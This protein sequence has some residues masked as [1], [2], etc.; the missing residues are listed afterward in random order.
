MLDGEQHRSATGGNG[1]GDLSNLR[2]VDAV[3][4]VLGGGHST[5]DG[6]YLRPFHAS[7]AEADE[8][9]HPGAIHHRLI[10]A[11]LSGLSR[12]HR[13]VLVLVDAENVE[14]LDVAGVAGVGECSEH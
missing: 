4:I 5:F 14:H 6:T 3:L 9:A 10:L 2:H 8:G 13:A 12:K 1:V 7:G 11:E